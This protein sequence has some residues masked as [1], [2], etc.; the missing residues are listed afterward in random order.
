MRMYLGSSCPN[1]P[2]SVEL[3]DMELST[4]IRGVLPFGADPNHGSGPVLLRE[5]V[6]CPWVSLLGL[7]FSYLCQSPFLIVSMLLCRVS[8]MRAQRQRRQVEGDAEPMCSQV[9]DV[10][11]LLRGTLAS[12]D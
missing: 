12:A 9:H 3:G 11:R 5:R 2:F 10:E 4:R 7:A 6:D 8:G 1:Y